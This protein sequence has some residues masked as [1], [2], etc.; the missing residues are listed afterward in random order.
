MARVGAFAAGVAAVAMVAVSAP[1][2]AAPASAGGGAGAMGWPGSCHT[3]IDEFRDYTSAQCVEANGGSYRAIA[4]CEG[5][6]G[7]FHRYGGWR[8]GGQSNAYC[9]GEEKVRAD[10]GAAI[11][12]RTW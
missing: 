5:P 4:I 11:E 9:W 3:A 7:T 6:M 1:A 10:D 2:Q 8:Q 12:T